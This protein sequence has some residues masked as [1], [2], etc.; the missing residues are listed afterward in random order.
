VRRISAAASSPSSPLPRWHAHVDD[1]HVR[2]VRAD[3]EQQAPGVGCPPDDLV[4]RI[5]EQRGD[6]FAQ[7]RVVIGDDHPQP[8]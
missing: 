6:A 8:P 1:G 7:E 5:L 2:L 3:L 4:A